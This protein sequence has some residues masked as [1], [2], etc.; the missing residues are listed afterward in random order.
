MKF[1]DP[2]A[3][4]GYEIFADGAG[5]LSAEIDRGAPIGRIA[6]GEVIFGELPQI[7]PVR[8]QVIVDD[9]ENDAEADRMGAIDEASEIIG[10]AVE[11]RRRE[12]INAV[13]TPAE[14]PGEVGHRHD[15]DHGYSQ[16]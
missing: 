15:L 5:V 6:V 16:T 12:Q 8:P 2:V 3:G 1:V 4:V 9:V 11:A 13:V 14:F 7:V 10:S